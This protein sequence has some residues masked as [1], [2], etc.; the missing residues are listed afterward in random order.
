MPFRED[1][2]FVYFSQAYGN[3]GIAHHALYVA[4]H[5]VVS[6]ATVDVAV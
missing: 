4:S 6:L 2:A 3:V 5:E 1:G